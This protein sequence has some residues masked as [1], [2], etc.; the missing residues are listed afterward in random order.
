MF[1][2]LKPHPE[3]GI[4]MA[5]K[6]G[7][8]GIEPWGNELQKYLSQPPEIGG[9]GDNCWLR[10]SNRC[11]KET[12]LRVHGRLLVYRLEAFAVDRSRHH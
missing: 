5:A 8:H 1:T 4:K 11:R 3:T 9:C 7:F 12:E 6:F 2:P 10:A